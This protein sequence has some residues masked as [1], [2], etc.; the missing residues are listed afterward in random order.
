MSV[1]EQPQ[2]RFTYRDYLTWPAD[3][4]WELIDGIPYA[5]FPAQPTGM[6]PA[7]TV[8]HQ[9]LV[10]AMT[11]QIAG[12]LQGKKCEAIVSP[13]DVLLPRQNEADEDI[14]DVVQPDL[15]VLCDRAK[16]TKRGIRGAPDFVVEV[17]S[18]ST[19]SHDQITKA[20]LYEKHG[21]QEFWVVD[22]IDRLVT[23]RVLGANGTFDPIRFVKAEG[24]VPVSLF[25]GF[26]FDFDV[27]FAR[28]SPA[29]DDST[30]MP[31]PTS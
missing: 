2:S 17:L 7:P 3:E 25:E 14:T 31:N 18:P 24:K 6:T 23:I 27:I 9:R 20:A 30:N 26:E 21:V 13:V 11:V 5:M 15:V 1:A 8:D 4:R 28:L 22:F 29:G 19:A 10:T 12:W 16:V